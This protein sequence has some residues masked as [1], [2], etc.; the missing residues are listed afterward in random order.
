MDRVARGRRLAPLNWILFLVGALFLSSVLRHVPGIGGI[1]RG[2]WGFW[3]AV[4]LLSGAFTWISARLLERKRLRS[5]TLELSHVESPHNLGKLGSLQLAHGRPRLA[6]SALERAVAGEPDSAEWHYRLGSALLACGE[7]ARAGIELERA[8]Q[9]APEHAY[10]EVALELGRARQAQGDDSGALAAWEGV[11]RDHGE[12]VRSAYLRGSALAK[13]G[14]REAAREA[15]AQVGR[16]AQR[17]PRFSRRGTL[18]WRA[19][20]WLQRLR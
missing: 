15:F 7:A 5:R 16:I 19:L 11:E 12:T 3:I 2:L 1:F 13:L 4:L 8:L 18:R 20:A 9:L 10:G 17:S 14:R 6:R